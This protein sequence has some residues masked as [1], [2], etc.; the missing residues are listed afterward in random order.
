MESSLE[1]ERIQI[2]DERSSFEGVSTNTG[3]DVLG[4]QE[5]RYM[6]NFTKPGLGPVSV[7]VTKDTYNTLNKRWSASD[8]IRWYKSLEKFDAGF[9][10]LTHSEYLAI[11]PCTKHIQT[12][13]IT[14]P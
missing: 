11:T 3:E 5:T 12:V 9:F 7:Q 8:E 4:V 10:N 13:L 6:A 2:S 1:K 14:R